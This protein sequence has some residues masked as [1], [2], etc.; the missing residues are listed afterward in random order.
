MAIYLL[1]AL[2]ALL[3]LL[4]VVRARRRRAPEVAGPAARTKTRTDDE[5]R[6]QLLV[7]LARDMRAPAA[8]AVRTVA[9]LR[10]ITAPF[11]AAPAIPTAE[12]EPDE[13]SWAPL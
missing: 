6:R 1:I 8:R 2:G 7:R 13:V 4:L 5:L 10:D 12:G 3:L 9:A 11:P